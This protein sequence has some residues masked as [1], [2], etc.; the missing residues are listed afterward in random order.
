VTT[1]HSKTDAGS[2]TVKTNLIGPAGAVAPGDPKS[3]DL[4]PSWARMIF[5]QDPDT[6]ANITPSTLIRG[7]IQFE[8]S[9]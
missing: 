5:E 9:A 7:R 4:N 3:P 8:R 2:A 1:R 6:A